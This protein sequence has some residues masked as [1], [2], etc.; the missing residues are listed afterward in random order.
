MSVILA[1]ESSCDDTSVAICNNGKIT[2][3]VIAN[4]TIHE[5][6]GGVIPELAS[7]VHQQNIVPAV[8]QALINAKVT[9]QDINAV[10]FTRG[11]G[12][13]GSLLVG[14]SFAKSFALALNIPLIS[15][16]HMHA[17]IL[18]HFID[19]PKPSFPFLCLT[20]SGGHTQIVLVKD[21]FD[22]EIVGETLDDAAGEAFDKTAKILQLPYP[23]GPLIDKHAQLGNAAAYKFA[24]PRIDN[25]NFSFSGF[26]TSIL[27]FIR[28]QEQEN[29]NFIVENL[30]DICASVQF[31]IIQILMNKLKKAAKQFG[32]TEIAIAGGVSANSGLRNTLQETAVELGWKVYIPAFQY[33]TDNAGMIAIAGYHKFLKQDFVGQEV[34]PMARMEF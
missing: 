11:P 27:Y 20:V 18:A 33:C 17:H 25:L 2:A 31:S 16:N 29:A 15:V 4:Q 22:M 26:K 12:L 6:Y 32:I 7:R 9:K 1:I 8:H 30:N 13:L 28:K 34:S 23:G 3:N 24:E 19:D 14:V 21:Y 5:N 10:A